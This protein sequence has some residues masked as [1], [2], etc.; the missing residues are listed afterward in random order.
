MPG[1]DI[2]R[3]NWNVDIIHRNVRFYRLSKLFHLKNW[4]SEILLGQPE[5]LLWFYTTLNVLNWTK[6]SNAD[7]YL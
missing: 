1:M 3:P 4:E 5:P 2:Q 6:R 7:I